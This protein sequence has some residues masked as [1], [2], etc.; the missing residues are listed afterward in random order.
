MFNVHIVCIIHCNILSDPNDK[1]Y[2][3]FVV[4]SAMIL[5]I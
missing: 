4:W 5:G 2:V 1:I 3:Q